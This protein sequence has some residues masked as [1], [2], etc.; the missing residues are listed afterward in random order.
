MSD[1]PSD[2]D[3][4]FLPDWLKEAPS[5][6]RYA[7]Y[8]GES[9]DRGGRGDR[10]RSPGGRPSGG[11][12]GPRNDRRSAA[13]KPGGPRPGGDRRDQTPRRD[14][15]RRDDRPHGGGAQGGGDRRNDSQSR[16]P[17]VP[18]APTV[19]VEFLPEPNGAA[20]I[21]KQIRSGSRAYPLFGTARLFLEKPER[22]RVRITSLDATKPLFQIDDGPISFDRAGLE[23]NAFAMFKDAYYQEEVIQG[24]PIK[25]N[26]SNV[27]RSRSTGAFLGPTNHHGY[28]P[29]LRN[30]YEDRFSRR[31][32]F[33]DFQHE[34]IVI[35]NTE[36]AIND[37]KEQ[38]RSSTT[39]TTLK[40]AEPTVFKSLNE[41]E[42]HF[43]KNY[44]PQLIKS[45]V[46]L[47]TNGASSRDCTDRSIL[48]GLRD[49]WEQERGFPGSLV[50]H[51]RPR[52]MDAG[53]HFFKHRKR[54]L[55]I[56]P[57]RPQRHASGELFSGNIASILAAIE[58]LPRITR[59]KLASK[60][61]GEQSESPDMLPKKAA[62]ASDLHYLIHAG[63]VIEFHDGALDLPLSPKAENESQPTPKAAPQAAPIVPEALEVSAETASP[64]LAELVAE[65]VPDAS[66]E[67]SREPASPQEVSIPVAS[68]SVS[69]TEVVS[70]ATQ[71]ADDPL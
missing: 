1:L 5:E 2:L 20:G 26:F 33:A 3:L 61:L 12:G 10:G 49:A 17:A 7:N 37:W 6:N 60:L 64:D 29:A 71:S 30:L 8:Q 14:Q 56:S 66:I 44:L 41:I 69:D 58:T 36:Q 70:V 62:L 28:Q 43:R 15:P 63:H 23:R 47:E 51:L 19:R 55:Y 25:G 9:P 40:E 35:V 31:M 4:K 59:P 18:Q 27:A 39:Y 22:H 50:H 42:Q 45:G 68:P 32:S 21:A 24:E 38:A 13:P 53:L 54:V 65:D 57:I 16:P 48:A 34:D 46:S 67:D 11:G 52:L